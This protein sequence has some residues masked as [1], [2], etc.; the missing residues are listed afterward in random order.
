MTPKI[1]VNIS[2]SV[3]L[4]V[5]SIV[6]FVKTVRLRRGT[7]KIEL[8][9]ER[10]AEVLLVL[11]YLSYLAVKAGPSERSMG[12]LDAAEDIGHMKHRTFLA[13]EDGKPMD[14]SSTY[15]ADTDHPFLR[16]VGTSSKEK[17]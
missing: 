13:T 15:Y 10:E 9:N 7:R 11:Q 17:S 6:M 2:V 1:V 5:F 12:I 14:K 16:R 3:V 8:Q 4:L